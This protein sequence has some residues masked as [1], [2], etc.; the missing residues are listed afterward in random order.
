MKYSAKLWLRLDAEQMK[1]IDQFRASSKRRTITVVIR[2]L[3]QKGLESVA[4]RTAREKLVGALCVL[5]GCD[6][7]SLAQQLAELQLK[8][9][10]MVLS[11]TRVRLD[12]RLCLK[13]FAIKGSRGRIQGLLDRI[14]ALDGVSHAWFSECQ[15]DA[16]NAK[17]IRKALAHA[18]S[19]NGWASAG[20]DVVMAMPLVLT[21]GAERLWG[22][23][24]AILPN[25]H[26]IAVSFSVH[27][28]RDTFLHVA[29]FK[30]S[31]A[32]DAALFPLS[33]GMPRNQS[34]AHPSA[35]PADGDAPNA[36]IGNAS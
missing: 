24:N 11:K 17:G 31:A 9:G 20:R 27:L 14:L 28:K 4:A 8:V 29:V 25:G 26:G 30:K 35:L 32:A 16:I 1:M 23:L 12:S 6:V 13:V 33:P 18:M 10:D 3:I 7:V 19:E 36:R 21:C 22:Q 2:H 15:G 34:A 5:Y